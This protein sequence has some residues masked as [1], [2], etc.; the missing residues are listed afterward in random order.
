MNLYLPIKTEYF[1]AIQTGEKTKEYRLYNDYWKKR[2]VGR[3]YDQ[4]IITKGYPK[5]DDESRRMC[6]KYSYYRVE[7]ITHPHF[8]PLP[9][10]VFAIP[11]NEG[12]H[13]IDIELA[14]AGMLE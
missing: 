12:M 11:L 9:V 4:I 5:R 1:D 2:L 8:G 7:T 14:R 6:F 3:D 10:K 13:H